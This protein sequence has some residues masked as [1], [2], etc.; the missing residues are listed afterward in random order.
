MQSSEP[1]GSRH[2]DS[3]GSLDRSSSCPAGFQCSKLTFHIARISRGS[4]CGQHR[5]GRNLNVRTFSSAWHFP[6][7]WAKKKTCILHT[8]EKQ[9]I[10]ALFPCTEFN[11]TIAWWIKEQDSDGTW[12]A[13]ISP[14][15]ISMLC[16]LWDLWL[17]VFDDWWLKILMND[18]LC[19]FSA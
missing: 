18:V 7:H 4:T 17:I 3:K 8:A 15:K 5:K 14:F 2:A 16:K 1:T 13:V 12:N 11:K 9:T 6:G 10:N 19:F